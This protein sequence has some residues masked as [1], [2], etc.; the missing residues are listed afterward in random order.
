MA[1]GSASDTHTSMD[2]AA[3][4]VHVIEAEEDLLRYLAHEGH[5]DALVLVPLD[6]AE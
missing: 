2:D 6:E 1:R 5:R 4:A 3:T